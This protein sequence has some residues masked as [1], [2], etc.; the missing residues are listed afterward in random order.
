MGTTVI[1]G[2]RKVAEG[3]CYG[4][5]H[6]F[7]GRCVKRDDG[8]ALSSTFLTTAATTINTLALCREECIRQPVSNQCTAYE[9]TGSTCKWFKTGK[10]LYTAVKGDLSAGSVCY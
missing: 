10:T 7:V 8:S 3:K 6:Q 1:Q 4:D 5:A 9:F 2:N